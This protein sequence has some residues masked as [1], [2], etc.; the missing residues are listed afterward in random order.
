MHLSELVTPDIVQTAIN[1]KGDNVNHKVIVVFDGFESE[2]SARWFGES[3]RR[4]PEYDVQDV[5]IV[6]ADTESK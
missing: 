3:F 2:E 4:S 1:F 5:Y 6:V